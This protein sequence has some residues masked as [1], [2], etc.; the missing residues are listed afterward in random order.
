MFERGKIVRV[1]PGLA[2]RDV[3]KVFEEM[4]P[5]FEF[6]D[7]PY[8]GSYRQRARLRTFTTRQIS[9]YIQATRFKQNAIASPGDSLEIEDRHRIEV[10]ILKEM[11]WCYVINNPSLAGQQYGQRQVI[12]NIFN[13]FKRAVLDQDWAILPIRFQEELERLRRSHGNDIPKKHRIRVA[14]DAVANM[15]DQQA[16][17]IH[18]R[19]FGVLPGSV[20]D[21]IIL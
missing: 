16:L 6:I 21:P 11:V 1:V 2:D 13:V 5:L 10:A 8:S 3:E 12:T 18:Q 17:R 7:E 4:V 14:A 15:T 9:I 20:L 19:F